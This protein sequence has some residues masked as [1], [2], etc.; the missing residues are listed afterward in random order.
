MEK[1]ESRK[2]DNIIRKMR[3]IKQS[4][5]RINSNGSI[6]KSKI[7]M[8]KRFSD[9]KLGYFSDLGYRNQDLII[10]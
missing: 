1:V 4:F 8:R 5:K 7:L 10:D 3:I 9:L 6:T 2:P